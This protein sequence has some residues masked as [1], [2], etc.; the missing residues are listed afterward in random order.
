MA[1]FKDHI[2]YLPLRL[3]ID[4][5][6]YA[7]TAFLGRLSHIELEPFKNN[8]IRFFNWLYR[9][10]VN[11]AAKA[12]FS[13]YRHFNAWFTRHL[14]PEL[15]PIASEDHSIC[16]PVD[17]RIIQIGDIQEGQLFPVK[18]QKLALNELLAGSE[19]ASLPFKQGQY[20]IL[21][22]SPQDY[23]RF[24]MPISGKLLKTVYV[25]GSLYSVSPLTAR[26]IPKIFSRNERAICYFST[27]LGT[28]AMILVG[29]VGVASIQLMWQE[30]LKPYSRGKVKT[31]EYTD[32]QIE[33]MQGKEVGYFNM[34]STVILLFPSKKL[35]WE[36]HLKPGSKIRMGEKI[37]IF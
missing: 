25:P 34:G 10:N 12:D 32:K 36:K 35:K 30:V 6:S 33:I 19:E 21:Y 20:A 24:H 8:M 3:F 17:G 31:W 2:R 28:M 22:L 11:D 5:C 23:H 9:V 16:S 27:G 4:P 15:R 29:A 13:D 37:A 1:T 7:W 14:R 18:G 26:V